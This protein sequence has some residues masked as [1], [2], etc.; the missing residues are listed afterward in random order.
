VLT[1]ADGSFG[2]TFTGGITLDGDDLKLKLG[3]S[4]DLEIYHSG[5][6]S[7]I[8]DVGNG[9]LRITA[10]RLTVLDEN[11]NETMI[12][13]TQ[14]AGVLLYYN[15]TNVLETVAVGAQS[16]F[17]GGGAAIGYTIHNEGTAAGDDVKIAFETQAAMDWAIGIDKSDSN[18]FKLSQSEN[19]GTND[20][21][22]IASGGAATFAGA[23]TLENGFTSEAVGL[24]DDGV[25][26]RFGQDRDLKIYESASK[27]FIQT[28]NGSTLKLLSDDI[29]L[30][31][32][33]GTESLAKF[34]ADGAVSLYYD[35]SVALQTKSGNGIIVNGDVALT[36]DANVE[37]ETALNSA[38]YTS[39]TIIKF[40]TGTTVAEEV[41]YLNT[42]GAWVATNA[43]ALASSYG[44]LAVA[45]GTSPTTHGMLTEGIYYDSGHS[46]AIGV[47]LYLNP[48]TS[49]T[50]T[51]TPPGS[52]D[53]A[54]IVGYAIDAN[55]IYFQP[56]KTWISVD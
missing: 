10:S 13:A 56:D 42:S 7:Y 39:G 1:L 6:D 38:G 22:T 36:G 4:Q 48:S 32:E 26:L 47:P 2:A 49:G 20:R 12:D 46:F 41:C 21:L 9:S 18:K 55:H 34:E 16:K 17:D 37:L 25:E 28:S 53:I 33:A 30:L 44:L 45:R 8:R 3:A 23:V 35:N 27:A 50:L 54:R 14:N 19:L 40:G 29:T 52:N 31:N 5:S 15:N 11:N 43:N 24:M 51:T